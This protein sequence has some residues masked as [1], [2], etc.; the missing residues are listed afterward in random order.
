MWWATNLQFAVL[1]LLTIG[2]LALL[3]VGLAS[4]FGALI[5]YILPT[6]LCLY[7]LYGVGY[8]GMTI[9]M[10]DNPVLEWVYAL[11]PQYARDATVYFLTESHLYRGRGQPGREDRTQAWSI[12]AL[13]IA[14]PATGRDRG[15]EEQWTSL[16]VAATGRDA[17]DLFL[18]SAAGEFYRFAAA[19]L[20]W[21]G[22]APVK[23]LPAVTPSATPCVQAVDP[24]I[25]L[26]KE[27]DL[28]DLGCAV[29]A[30]KETGA[31]FQPFERGAMFWRE[32]V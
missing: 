8:L 12:A 26:P 1:F 20:P 18:G 19:E 23:A 10:R 27:A 32:L 30:G 11:S 2:P 17:H 31:A 9:K 5:G 25:P 28:A 4:R 3:G 24:R 14:G 21:T 29:A 22:V 15:F 6:A 16:A 7:G 13:P